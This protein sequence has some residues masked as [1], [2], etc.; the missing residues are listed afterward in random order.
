MLQYFNHYIKIATI[1]FACTNI[2]FTSFL[3][4]KKQDYGP[5]LWIE[6]NCLEAAEPLQKDRLLLTTKSPRV[7]GTYLTNPG[8]M[9][10]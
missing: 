1:I 6:F 8:R 9:K 4:K 10:D 5:F 2:K 7:P 3:I